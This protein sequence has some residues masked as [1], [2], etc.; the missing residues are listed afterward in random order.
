MS[1]PDSQQDDIEFDTDADSIVTFKSHE[2]L[3]SP[4]EKG[5]DFPFDYHRWMSDLLTDPGLSGYTDVDFLLKN[6]IGS[7]VTV[8]AHRL[9]LATRNKHFAEMLQH[10]KYR[11]IVLTDP[12]VPAEAFQAVVR[13]IYTG[14]VDLPRNVQQVTRL[15]FAA[16]KFEVEPLYDLTKDFILRR[17]PRG[18]AKHV[19]YLFQHALDLGL[20]DLFPLCTGVLE[21]RTF[22]IIK[23]QQ[24]LRTKANFISQL[25]DCD[26]FTGVTERE[27]FDAVLHW[28]RSRL[29]EIAP[30][31][32]REKTLRNTLDS[33]IYK[34]RLL[35]IPRDEL[36]VLITESDV[37]YEKEQLRISLYLLGRHRDLGDFSMK[38]RRFAQREICPS[39]KSLSGASVPRFAGIRSRRACSEE[40][41][42]KSTSTAELSQEVT[43]A[44]SSE[45]SAAG[46]V[47]KREK[48]N[49]H[50]GKPTGTDPSRHPSRKTCSSSAS[51]SDKN[52]CGSMCPICP[53]MFSYLSSSKK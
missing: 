11:E 45:G 53:I 4:S 20:N 25:L 18:H 28:G 27:V 48:R 26:V 2:R 50:I 39:V 40:R 41:S 10:E 37:F 19:I 43:V 30:G 24:F 33:F 52:V 1:N 14:D 9:V 22:E 42:R 13:Y 31:G 38:I 15:L 35:S 32:D 29:A 44:S 49:L 16:K 36:T 8:S 6:L 5:D 47:L 7:H 3:S 17:I 23:E 51:K 21:Q 34:F 46:V 12:N